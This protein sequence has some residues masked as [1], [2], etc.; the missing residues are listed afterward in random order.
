MLLFCFYIALF[1]FVSIVVL[2]VS[3]L[4]TF[5][6]L[7]P[8]L[9]I[10]DA[11]LYCVVEFMPLT[12]AAPLHLYSNLHCVCYLLNYNGLSNTSHCFNE[13]HWLLDNCIF[14]YISPFS[15]LC[16]ATLPQDTG[17]L[18]INHISHYHQQCF[19]RKL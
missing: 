11:Q 8:G 13:L 10:V 15:Q 3:S 1:F 2:L 18:H 19:N 12:C 7:D 5:R 16:L 14:S 6:T 9:R 4:Y 17:Y